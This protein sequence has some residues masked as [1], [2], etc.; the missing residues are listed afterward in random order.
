[1][2]NWKLLINV[3]NSLS[4]PPSQRL[5][6]KATRPFTA[7]GFERRQD[8]RPGLCMTG[9]CYLPLSSSSDVKQQQ[10]QQGKKVL[11]LFPLSVPPAPPEQWLTY[12]HA[13]LTNVV[14]DPFSCV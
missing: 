3:L 12:M 13:P 11:P 10:G 7:A 5:R 2:R 14:E 1:M 6:A 4:D 8:K 9:G